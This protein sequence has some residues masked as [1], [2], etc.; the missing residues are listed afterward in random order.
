M[1]VEKLAEELAVHVSVLMRAF[2]VSNRQ[3]TPAEGKLPF[4]PLYFN[5]L[6]LLR[7]AGKATP[8]EIAATLIVPR[9]TVST[10]IKALQKRELLET[11]PSKSDGR[12]IEVFLSEQGKEAVQAI[13][14]QDL[15][16][17]MA[18]LLALKDEDREQF[19]SS[20]QEIASFV[21]SSGSEN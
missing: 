18:M 19:V 10:A 1:S 7:A 9:T 13:L 6:K 3:G 2:L 4:N 14:R 17:S 21:E 5:L 20:F 12:S 8:S 11:A 15:R 16:N